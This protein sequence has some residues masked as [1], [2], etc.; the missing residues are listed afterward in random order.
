MVIVPGVGVGLKP[1]PT[2]YVE[3][4]LGRGFATPRGCSIAQLGGPHGNRSLAVCDGRSGAAMGQ[5]RRRSSADRGRAGARGKSLV[6]LGRNPGSNPPKSWVAATLWGAVIPWV[7]MGSG[8]H[9]CGDPKACGGPMGCGDAV[10]RADPIRNGGPR[11]P[12]RLRRLLRR[13]DGRQR[14][15]GVRRSNGLRAPTHGPRRY[16]EPRR[17]RGQWRPHKPRRTHGRRRPC[18][19]RQPMGHG[20]PMG[21][22]DPVGSARSIGR[23]GPIG[24]GDPAGWTPR[25]S[26]H[27]PP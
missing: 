18:G 3:A 14:V 4:P 11:R 2:A 17:P 26:R 12:R 9:A 21:C 24:G 6:G 23:G 19:L 15:H 1:S 25:A 8:D 10:G 7:A 27:V 20:A 13:F 22:G 5:L 16:H